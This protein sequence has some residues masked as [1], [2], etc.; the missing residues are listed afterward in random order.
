MAK[1]SLPDGTAVSPTTNL[2]KT[3]SSGASSEVS[4]DDA[5]IGTPGSETYEKD[6]FDKKGKGYIYD[7][8]SVASLA[9]NDEEPPTPGRALLIFLK[10]KKSGSASSQ[11]SLDAVSRLSS[12]YT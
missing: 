9:P 12:D 11:P 2:P 6:L 5:S 7:V 8:K 10:L 3:D 1:E 4:G